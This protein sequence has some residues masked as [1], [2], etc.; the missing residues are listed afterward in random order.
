A[1]DGGPAI[2]SHHSP[3]FK[4]TPKPA[5]ITGTQATIHALL[6]LMPSS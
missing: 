5:V 3:L 6:E 4:I 2:P 1:K